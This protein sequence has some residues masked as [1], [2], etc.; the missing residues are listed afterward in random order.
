MVV[1]VEEGVVWTKALVIIRPSDPVHTFSSWGE[2]FLAQNV[3][4]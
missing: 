4:L 2:V 3:L 1:L